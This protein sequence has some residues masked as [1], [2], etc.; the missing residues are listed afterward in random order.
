MCGAVGKGACLQRTVAVDVSD[1]VDS[2][3]ATTAAVFIEISF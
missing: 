1:V 3:P 2:T